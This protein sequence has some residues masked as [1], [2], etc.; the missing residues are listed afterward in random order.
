MRAALALL[1]LAFAA[2]ALAA[3]APQV[4]VRI[5]QSGPIYVGQSVRL[6]V[7]VLVPNFFMSSPQFP[8]FDLPGAVV[9][10]P[11]EGAVNVSET[12]DGVTYAGI[13]RSYVIVFQREG[14]FALPPARITFQYAAVPGQPSPGSVTLPPQKLDVLLPPGAKSAHGALPVARITIQQQVEGLTTPLH[15]GD[16]LTRT[17]EI[18][19]DHTQ[20]MMIPP[21]TFAAPAGVRIYR[22]DPQLADV[23]DKQGQFLGGRRVDVATYLFERP[24]R[25]TLPAISVNWFDPS[26]KRRQVARAPEIQLSVVASAQPKGAIA[27]APPPQGE[28]LAEKSIHWGRWLALASAALIGLLAIYRLFRRHA[29]RILA[30]VAARRAARRESE[31]AY[32]SRLLAAC[33]SNDPVRSYASLGGWVRRSGCASIGSYL[34]AA[35]D[36]ELRKQVTQLE[37]RLYSGATASGRWNGAQ[38]ATALVKA[39]RSL[40]RRGHRPRYRLSALNPAGSAARHEGGAAQP[41]RTSRAGPRAHRWWVADRRG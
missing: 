39:R 8:L 12:I 2:A 32:F 11:G 7:T 40:V 34:Q 35:A 5:E 30:F 16:A 29:G 38:L 36:D 27:P 6:D 22:K 25:Y 10:M 41:A 17:I 37:Q 15:A 21:P 4:R 9:T 1:A 31:G 18:F 14:A 26:S 24:G 19:A 33:R 13:Q 28:S 3:E 20:S 23:T